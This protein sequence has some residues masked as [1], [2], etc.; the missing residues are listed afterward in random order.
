MLSYTPGTPRDLLGQMKPILKPMRVRKT[1]GGGV[2]AYKLDIDKVIFVLEKE[3][4][5]NRSLC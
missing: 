1:D 2:R 4:V 3:M 5:K